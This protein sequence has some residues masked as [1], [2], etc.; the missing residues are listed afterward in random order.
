M[1]EYLINKIVRK[2]SSLCIGGEKNP[3]LIRYN[4]KTKTVVYEISFFKNNEMKK[5]TGNL[6]FNEK[7][8]T[9]TF[10]LCKF[11]FTFDTDGFV[12]KLAV[13]E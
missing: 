10:E 5:A 4:Y 9:L 3:T 8:G 7:V 13:K 12:L 2:V 11:S 6:D 1:E